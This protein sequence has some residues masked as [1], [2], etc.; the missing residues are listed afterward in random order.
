MNGANSI[1]QYPSECVTDIDA[2]K[3]NYDLAVI[4][5][6]YNSEN[7]LSR[8]IKSVLEQKNKRTVLILVN[9]GSTDSSSIIARE[10]TRDRSDVI[11][12]EQVNKGVAAARNAGIELAI[13]VGAK[14]VGFL[15]SDDAWLKGA[16]AG[17]EKAIQTGKDVYEFSYYNAN[18]RLTR[19]RL[20]PAREILINGEI[21]RWGLYFWTYVYK[22]D[23]IKRY[24]IR[25]PEGIVPHE[26]EAFRYLFL[27]MSKTGER[28]D[29][30]LLAYRSN[31][32]SITRR[33]RPDLLTKYKNVINAWYYVEKELMR[34]RYQYDAPFGEGDM[35][36]CASMRK[37]YIIEFIE[38]ALKE[39]ICPKELKRVV[40]DEGWIEI[41]NDESLWVGKKQTIIWSG[42]TNAPNSLFL[43]KRIEGLSLKHLRKFRGLPIVQ[44][45]RYPEQIECAGV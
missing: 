33:K 45:I 12:A 40:S 8:A 10:T 35:K 4:I 20:V 16:F 32:I 42:F 13:S 5:P 44:R 25:F 21:N 27:S 31:P 9:D 36:A 23:I 7:F 18:E 41:L 19:G 14:Y 38:E 22:V 3:K 29:I 39:G 34:L 28:F 24:L 43:K 17:I 26:D 2:S 1:T 11:I 30:P 6:F 15:D 37:N